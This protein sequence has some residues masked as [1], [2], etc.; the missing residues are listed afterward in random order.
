MNCGDSGIDHP[1]PV[2]TYAPNPWGLY[3]MHGNVGEWCL[4]YFGDY[5]TGTVVDPTGPQN[6]SHRVCRGGSWGNGAWCCRS[7]SRYGGE[8]GYRRYNLGFRVLLVCD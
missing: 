6:V 8:L 7:A 3:D 1:T 2:K 5:P 4:D